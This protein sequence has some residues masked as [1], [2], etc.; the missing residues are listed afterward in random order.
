MGLAWAF[1]LGP[2]VTCS[3]AGRGRR[4]AARLTWARGRC[5]APGDMMIDCCDVGSHVV[6]ESV[7]GGWLMPGT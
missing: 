2:G 6:S 4:G 3:I 5:A 1:L 7:E